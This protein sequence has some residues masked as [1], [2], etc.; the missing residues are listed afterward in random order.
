ME[1]YLA[2]KLAGE[3]ERYQNKDFLKAAM[4]AFVLTAHADGNIGSTE[5]LRIDESLKSEPGLRE[6]DFNKAT[7]I[8]D[9]YTNA[10]KNE[11]ELAKRVL[12]SKVRQMAG[13]Y[14]QART[15]MRICYL[16]I[17]ADGII[18][19]V[20]MKEFRQLCGLLR[21]EPAEIW[22]KSWDRPQTDPR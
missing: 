21:V 19:D 11:K 13:N 16:I 4:A 5:R 6:F 1:S 20:E 22:P 18:H 10:L 3:V 12:Y 8:L 7:E 2:D 15:V 9:S 17:R 14:K